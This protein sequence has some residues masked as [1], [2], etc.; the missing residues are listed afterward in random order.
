[1][2][3]ETSALKNRVEELERKISSLTNRL[4]QVDISC[5][6]KVDALDSNVMNLMSTDITAS[7]AIEV[8]Y[9]EW[10]GIEREAKELRERTSELDRRGMEVQFEINKLLSNAIGCEDAIKLRIS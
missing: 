5:R 2:G 10:A 9:I 3:Y 8:L 4:E 1:M 7:K 6:A